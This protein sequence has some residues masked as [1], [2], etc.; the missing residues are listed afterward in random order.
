MGRDGK[1]VGSEDGTCGGQACHSRLVGPGGTSKARLLALSTKSSLLGP[2]TLGLGVAH[3]GRQGRGV[4]TLS[5][6]DGTGGNLSFGILASPKPLELSPGW[7]RGRGLARPWQARKQQQQQRPTTLG[8]G[9][10]GWGRGW[11]DLMLVQTQ[12]QRLVTP[13]NTFCM[14]R[15]HG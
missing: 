9:D 7:G 8:P 10:C 11:G 15:H 3:W 6:P 13:Q 14:L 4:R 12:G 1:P 5:L 2:W